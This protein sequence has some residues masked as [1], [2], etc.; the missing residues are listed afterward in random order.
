MLSAF[1]GLLFFCSMK[2]VN[3]LKGFAPQWFWR[4]LLFYKLAKS[5]YPWHACFRNFCTSWIISFFMQKKFVNA[6]KEFSAQQSKMLGECK[7]ANKLW[8]LPDC[9]QPTKENTTWSPTQGHVPENPLS[10][11]F[12]TPF[13]SLE[14][15]KKS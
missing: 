15:A 6:L 14:C 2:S 8:N 11:I 7:Q 5:H 1:H 10:P 12:L 9:T 3:M 13:P 4:A